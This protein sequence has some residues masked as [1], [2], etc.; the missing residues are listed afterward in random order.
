M[1]TVREFEKYLES[2]SDDEYDKLMQERMSRL[3]D[4][5]QAIM[6][7]RES[8]RKDRAKLIA[9]LDSPD[10]DVH[11]MVFNALRDMDGDECEH[12]RSYCK[13]CIACGKIDHAMFP[14]MFDEDG[15]RIED[16]Q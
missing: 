4:E 2:L 5:Q 11:E 16:D 13:H 1:P 7:V 8:Q 12:Q 10:P 3:N 6:R 15:F 14:E 9:K